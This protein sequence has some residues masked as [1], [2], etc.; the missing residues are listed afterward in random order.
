M[1]L[2]ENSLP[3]LFLGFPSDGARRVGVGSVLAETVDLV[4][5]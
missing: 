4:M 1:M 5:E 2:S 3:T